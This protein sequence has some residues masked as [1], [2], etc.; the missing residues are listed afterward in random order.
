MYDQSIY[1]HIYKNIYNIYKNINIFTFSQ[2]K[3]A[4]LPI[5]DL[6]FVIIVCV[7]CA[8]INVLMITYR[9]YNLLTTQWQNLFL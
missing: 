3:N 6:R 2:K 5:K 1:N 7:L 9:Q 8:E 4:V